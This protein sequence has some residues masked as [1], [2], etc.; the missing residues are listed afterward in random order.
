MPFLNSNYYIKLR[1]M[2]L[3]QWLRIRGREYRIRGECIRCG[4]CCRSI[5][6]KTQK[7][8]IKKNR[9]FLHLKKE[10]PDY[11]R[12]TPT[13]VDNF[14]FLQF[15]CKLYIPHLGCQDYLNRLDICK[16]YPTK[17]LPLHG[18]QLLEGCGY[19]FECV[20]PFKKVLAAEIKKRKKA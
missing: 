10:N 7:G 8:W 17:Y 11:A 18:G 16:N 12:F 14:G 1:Y 6:L 19:R 9:E 5:N 15:H 2:I 4:K 20:K 3:R 13:G